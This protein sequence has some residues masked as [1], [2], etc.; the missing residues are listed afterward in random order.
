M[1]LSDIKGERVF[2]VIADIVDPAFNIASDK[3]ALA[4]FKPTEEGEPPVDRFHRAIPVLLRDHRDDLIDIM[5]A[6]NGVPREE[7]LATLTIGSLIK[8]VYEMMTDEDL[9]SFLS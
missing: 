3:D 6:I 7:Y 9:L 8:D 5:V 4:L 2:N 1:R